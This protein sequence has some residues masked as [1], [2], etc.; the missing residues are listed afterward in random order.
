MTFYS[1]KQPKYFGKNTKVGKLTS[2]NIFNILSSPTEVIQKCLPFPDPVQ[3][4]FVCVGGG[5]II[6]AIFQAIGS[7]LWGKQF[8][9]TLL[10]DRK[11]I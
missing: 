10:F 1:C 8:I 6:Y 2:F 4:I 5:G 9:G 11:C 7:L 3:M